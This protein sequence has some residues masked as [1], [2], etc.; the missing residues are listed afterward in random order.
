MRRAMMTRRLRHFL[1]DRRGATAIEYA[2]IASGIAAVLVG[3]ISTLGGKVVALW[4]A[5]QGA[6]H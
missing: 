1:R 3:V 4:T 2:I 5:V 6:F